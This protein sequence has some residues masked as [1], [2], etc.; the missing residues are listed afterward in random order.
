[1]N[2]GGVLRALRH[3]NFRILYPA[4]AL[5]NI[6]TW[7]QRVAQDWLVLQLT[8]SAQDLGIVTGLQFLPTLAFSL[9]A[10]VLADRFNKRVL[11]FFTNLG[12]GLSAATLGFLV[13]S[14][15]VQIWQVY[16]L[17]FILGIFSAL[18][19]PIRQSFTSELVSKTDLANAVS[20]NS[21]NFNA[22]RLIGPGLSGVLIAAF[23]TGPSFFINS[24]SYLALMVSIALIREND[25]HLTEKPAQRATMRE[26]FSYVKARPDLRFIMI[27]VF[28]ATTFGLNF[29]IFNSLMARLEFGLGPAEFGGLGSILAVGSLSGALIAMRLEHWRIPKRIMAGAIV[30]GVTLAL[31][32]LAPN[33]VSY[34]IVLPFAGTIAL[35]TMISANSYVQT[36]THP[37]LRGRVM[38]IYL[39]I[40]MGGTPIGSP[41]I[42][43][44]AELI[45]IRM[46][47]FCCGTVAA[48]ACC[49]LLWRFSRLNLDSYSSQFDV[50]ERAK[51]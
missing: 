41:L 19:A 1:V 40:F 30:F 34:S 32:S 24:L 39:L 36:H 21:A 48:V 46:T 7:S 11:L 9:W 43:F 27:T 44:F 10:G 26:A 6:G 33:Y 20:L 45:G 51:P 35:L 50:A 22:G 16:L 2:N 14:N 18:D 3:R 31:L 13:V 38:G 12:A 23:G 47:I 29:Q 42:G 37:H 28:F 49:V 8:N 4:L 25:L 17:A 5:S 15:Q